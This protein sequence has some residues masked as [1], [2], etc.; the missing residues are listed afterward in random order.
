MK[1]KTYLLP[2]LVSIFVLTGIFAFKNKSGS[3]GGILSLRTCE[4]TLGPRDNSITIVY[5]DSK[6]EKI[7]LKK[8]N[9][10]DMS[11]N[12]VTI[13]E[14][15]NKIKSQGYRLLSTADGSTDGRIMITYTFEKN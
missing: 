3:Q 9:L 10:N 7:E 6:I 11:V 12:F 2:V 14:C 8:L 5:E 13:N 1:R 15:L 4:T